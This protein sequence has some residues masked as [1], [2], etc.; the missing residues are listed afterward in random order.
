[1]SY[2][3]VSPLEM[4]T[5]GLCFRI[6][7][8]SGIDLIDIAKQYTYCHYWSIEILIKTLIDLTKH[9]VIVQ[10]EPYSFAKC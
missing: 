6:Q 2:D 5:A 10:P 7:G 9:C 1:M 3:P 8:L 4:I